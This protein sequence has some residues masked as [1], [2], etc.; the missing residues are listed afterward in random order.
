MSPEFSECPT[1]PNIEQQ[2]DKGFVLL[3]GAPRSGQAVNARAV[4][5]SDVPVNGG[6][7]LLA[8]I[9]PFA[10]TRKW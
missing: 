10:L 6:A 9:G 2:I 3:E 7:F 4:V 5:V 1:I 8:E